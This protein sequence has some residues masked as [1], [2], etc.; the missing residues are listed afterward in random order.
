MKKLPFILSLASTSLLLTGCSGLLKLLFT[1][2]EKGIKTADEF[3]ATHEDYNYYLEN[4][5]DFSSYDVGTKR[6]I[7][8][9]DFDG[10]G[11][12]LKGLKVDTPNIRY[13]Y[14]MDFAKGATVKDLNVEDFS[15]NI[16]D[17]L[18]GVGFFD[19]VTKNFEFKNVSLS[20]TINCPNTEYV[21][22][23]T[24][25]VKN[26][27]NDIKV[28]FT[29]CSSKVHVTGNK[30]VG[31]FIGAS[32][33]LLFMNNCTNRGTIKSSGYAGGMVGY[34]RYTRSAQLLESQHH[35]IFTG[36]INYGYVGGQSYVGGIAGSMYSNYTYGSMEYVYF[37][38][39][40]NCEN[41]Y[42]VN[43]VSDYCGGIAGSGGNVTDF[44]GCVNTGS[45]SYCM[46]QA[47]IA[48]DAHSIQD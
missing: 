48:N 9:K 27:E 39:V 13:A 6:A 41:H 33:E 46:H 11:F 21:G 42:N 2:I 43:V 35:D 4:D 1:P 18:D 23:F 38:N 8:R 3:F 45:V 36:C 19:M 14:I 10:R 5:I 29:D 12:T 20:G 44:Y 16:E 28:K 34:V 24:C 26:I 32:Q 15:I 37:F 30:Y 17:K 7:F 22:G 47:D 40:K 25:Q 31:G